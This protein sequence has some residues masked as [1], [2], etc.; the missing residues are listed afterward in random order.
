LHTTRKTLVN[1]DRRRRTIE[2]KNPCS[3][4]I[5][6]D[7]HEIAAEFHQTQRTAAAG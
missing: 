4:A 2:P 1:G 3:R 5:A 6:A 7:P